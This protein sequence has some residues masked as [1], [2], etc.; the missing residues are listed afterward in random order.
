MVQRVLKEGK[1]KR[2]SRTV[3]PTLMPENKVARLKFALSMVNHQT[4]KFSN[5]FNCIHVDEKFFYM[6]KIKKKFHVLP[7]EEIPTLTCK[8][9]RFIGKVMLLAAVARP[10]YDP[11]R[12]TQFDGKIGICNARTSTK[13][14][15][16]PSPRDIGDKAF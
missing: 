16:K 5:L 6:T 4:G 12:K 14:F 1:I 3:K 11:H 8:S 7:E 13:K 9:K 10:R 15:E 2:V